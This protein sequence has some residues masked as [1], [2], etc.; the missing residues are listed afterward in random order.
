MV[1]T[2]EITRKLSEKGYRLTPQRGII[3]SVL[4]KSQGHISAEEI[5]THISERHPCINISTVYR[6]L[7]LLL[8]L[9]LVIRVDRGDGLERYQYVDNSEHHH[10]VCSNCGRVINVAE[11]MLDDFRQ[12]AKSRYGFEVQKK[13][14]AFSGLCE[15][16]Q[17]R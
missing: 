14:L 8:K 13:H 9:G 7:E 6:T 10:L 16:C 2:Q 17:R 3:L 4:V 11:N 15:D 5:Y 1:Q 12:R